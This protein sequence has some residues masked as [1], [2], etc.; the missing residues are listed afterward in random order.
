MEIISK[1]LVIVGGGIS[2]LTLAYELIDKGLNSNDLFLLES[3]ERVGG[4]ITAIGK[5][6]FRV[7]GGPNGFLDSKPPTIELCKKLGIADQMLTSSDLA[8]KRYVFANHQLHQLPESPSTLL[9]S[10][11]LSFGAKC[12]LCCEPFIPKYKLHKD[13]TLESFAIRRLGKEAYEK[14]LDPMVSGVFAGNPELM[15]LRSSFPRIWEIEQEY[16]SLIRGMFKLRKKMKQTGSSVAGPG[17]KLTSFEPG[18][19]KLPEVLAEKLGSVIRTNSKVERIEKNGDQWNVYLQGGKCMVTAD[20]LAL[21][22]PAY[23]SADLLEPLNAEFAEATRQIPYAHTTVLGLGYKKKDF[24]HHLNGFGFLIPSKEKSE[25]LGCLWTSSIFPSDRCPD[26]SVLLRII[27]GGARR[28][29]LVKFS[30]DELLDKALNAL[31]ETMGIQEK[32]S[33]VAIQKWDQAI[34]QYL[35]HHEKI[36]KKIEIFRKQYQGLYLGGNAYRGV[37]LPDCVANSTKLAEQIIKECK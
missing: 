32:P 4:K 23:A 33:F 21:M 29:D 3:E 16:G 35:V 5:Q 18:L 34:P 6:G 24:P 17:G 9:K 1:K 19:S 30:E 8:R 12:R 25:I 20:T 28:P 36:L 37:S 26:D 14:L 10:S 13:E 15:S 22:S 27:M 7:E 2:G 11:L 31:K